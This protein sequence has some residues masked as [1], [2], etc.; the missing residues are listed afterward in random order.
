MTMRPLFLLVAA[1]L[2]ITTAS[3]AWG[4]YNPTVG[5]FMQRD[6]QGTVVMPTFLERSIGPVRGSSFIPRD[7]DSI[8]RLPSDA[9][10]AAH[11]NMRI[12]PVLQYAD[13]MSLYQY[14]GSSPTGYLDP[15]GLYR[16][17]GPRVWL[18]TSYWCTDHTIW[19]AAVEAAGG[20]ILC[21]WDCE[22]S[23]HCNAA[24]YAADAAGAA[25]TFTFTHGQ[26]S[27]PPDLIRPGASDL[28]TL[29]SRLSYELRSRGYNNLSKPLRLGARAVKARPV[30]AG[31]GSLIAG[32]AMAEAGISVYCG[33]KCSG[34]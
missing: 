12:N 28:T 11:K 13:G 7:L 15:S 22:V 9:G 20:A 29:Q 33:W 5:R 25:A 26:F 4:M 27:K 34:L 1:L 10:N 17:C 30:A 16:V 21:W 8:F 24:A 6:P 18:Y 32:A 23:V 19:E 14:V 3:P 31:A 2:F